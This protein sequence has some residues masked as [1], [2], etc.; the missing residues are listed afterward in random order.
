MLSKLSEIL[1]KIDTGQELTDYSIL[2]QDS[3]LI[4]KIKKEGELDD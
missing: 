1:D 3:E 4:D 2:N